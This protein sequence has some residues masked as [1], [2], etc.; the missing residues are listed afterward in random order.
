[1]HITARITFIH[2]FIRSSNIWLS[3]ILNCLGFKYLLTCFSGALHFNSINIRLSSFYEAKKTYT[4]FDKTT[5]RHEDFRYMKIH[6]FAVKTCSSFGVNGVLHVSDLIQR[7]YSSLVII[8]PIIL[9]Q[10]WPCL[11]HLPGKRIHQDHTLD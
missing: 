6:I 5:L 10:M 8:F 11:T 4:V 3:Y 2:I 9:Y 7:C 1:M